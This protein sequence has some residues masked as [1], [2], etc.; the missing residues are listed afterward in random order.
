MIIRVSN[1]CELSPTQAG[2]LF[3]S[4]SEGTSRVYMEQVVAKLHEPVDN[5]IARKASFLWT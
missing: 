5:A 4:E 2:T 1:N 3:H